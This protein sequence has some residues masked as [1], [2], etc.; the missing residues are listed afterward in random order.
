MVERLIVKIITRGGLSVCLIDRP[1]TV[2]QLTAECVFGQTMDCQ[3]LP[4]NPSTLQGSKRF[5]YS[6]YLQESFASLHALSVFQILC[7]KQPHHLKW[8]LSTNLTYYPLCHKVVAGVQNNRF[9]HLGRAHL[10][11]E[12]VPGRVVS[13]PSHREGLWITGSRHV[14]KRIW[15]AYTVLV[16]WYQEDCPR[17]DETLQFGTNFE[18]VDL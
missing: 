17:F 9:L 7:A 16:E 4:Y 15:T 13:Y 18:I 2:G 10:G 8:V 1:L 14:P 6:D 11:T 5:L 3:V 12:I